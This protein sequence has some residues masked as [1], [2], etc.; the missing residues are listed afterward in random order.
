MKDNRFFLEKFYCVTFLKY[1][2]VHEVFF[3]FNFYMNENNFLERSLT[4]S[5]LF[6]RHHIAHEVFYICLTFLLIYFLRHPFWFF[7][8]T[9]FMNLKP[10]SNLNMKRINFHWIVWS[11]RVDPPI[12]GAD[13]CDSITDPVSCFLVLLQKNF[14]Q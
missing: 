4:F 12:Y 1:H 5:F 7:P 11:T 9:I 14:R 3:S 6:L 8:N 2:I 13:V 10:I